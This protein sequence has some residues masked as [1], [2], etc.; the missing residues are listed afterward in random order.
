MLIWKHNVP[1]WNF[2]NIIYQNETKSKLNG[3]KITL[4]LFFN[5]TQK[6]INVNKRYF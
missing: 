4:S 6:M 3:P 1:K 2:L 5:L